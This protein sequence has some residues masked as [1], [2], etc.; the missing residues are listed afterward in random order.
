MI[1]DFSETEMSLEI[2]KINLN[3]FNYTTPAF[4]FVNVKNDSVARFPKVVVFT[5]LL[6]KVITYTYEL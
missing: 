1:R 4:K 3:I 6:L 5:K 2:Y